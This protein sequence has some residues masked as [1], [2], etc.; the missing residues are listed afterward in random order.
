ML[1]HVNNQ[2]MAISKVAVN[3]Q[4]QQLIDKTANKNFMF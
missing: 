4:T 3:K 1:F 2:V